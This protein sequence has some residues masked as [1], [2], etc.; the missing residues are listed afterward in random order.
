MAKSLYDDASAKVPCRR[1]KTIEHFLEYKSCNLCDMK[2]DFQELGGMVITKKT[3]THKRK[4]TSKSGSRCWLWDLQAPSPGLVSGFSGALGLRGGWRCMHIAA[5]TIHP[6][7]C[8]ATPPQC[9]GSTGWE[10]VER[11]SGIQKRH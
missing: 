3:H 8:D 9:R 10:R 7:L 5:G 11:V 6:S 4:A 2:R 1:H